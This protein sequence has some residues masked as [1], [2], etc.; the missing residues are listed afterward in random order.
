MTSPLNKVR[1]LVSQAGRI[2]VVA[3]VSP[4]GDT[5]GACLGLAWGLR[6]LGKDV[7]LTCQ[8]AVPDKLRFLDGSTAFAPRTLTDEDLVMAIDCSDERRMGSIYDAHR[9]AFTPMIVIDH[10]ITNKGFGSVNVLSDAA[11]T[12]EMIIPVLDELG[13]S[14]DKRIADCLLTGVV[15]DTQGFRTS[16]VTAETL[17]A[18]VRLV[19]A[20]ADMAWVSEQAFNQRPLATVGLWGKALSVAQVTDSVIWTEIP[21]AWLG[22]KTEQAD[23]V[24]GLVSFM[25]SMEGLRASAVFEET[26][27]GQVDVS[28]RASPGLNVSGVAV[29]FGGGGHPQAAGCMVPGTLA[30]VRSRVVAALVQVVRKSVDGPVS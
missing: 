30:D 6:K 25:L 9:F 16:N 22:Q 28:L 10:H 3:H 12:C 17:S 18:A 7:R 24:D 8:D 5:L 21:L 20:G 27:D 29:A 4:D 2:L 15:T 23:P 13:V 11:S 26:A 1:E 14:L 19:D